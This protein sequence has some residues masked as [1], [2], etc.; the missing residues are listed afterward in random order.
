MAVFSTVTDLLEWCVVRWAEHVARMGRRCM[1]TGF[2]GNTK[3]R[4]CLENIGIDVM[5]TLEG[6]L[7]E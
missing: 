3:E 4:D 7:R 1:C 5:V 6:M 2:G